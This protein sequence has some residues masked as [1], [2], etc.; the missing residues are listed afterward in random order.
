MATDALQ[1]LDEYEKR[2]QPPVGGSALDL[3]D[4]YERR[5]Q[6]RPYG[7]VEPP[8]PAAPKLAPGLTGAVT[9]GLA[10]LGQSVGGALEAF[11]P[12]GSFLGQT[13]QQL[14]EAVSPYVQP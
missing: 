3:L 2:S 7:P 5:A 13:G 6:G 1:L 4:E 10:S 11:T 9:S 8:T 14:R 12:E